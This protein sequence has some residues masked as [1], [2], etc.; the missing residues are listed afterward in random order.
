MSHKTLIKI[1]LLFCYSFVLL[2][3]A[4]SAIALMMARNFFTLYCPCSA[5]SPLHYIISLFTQ[6]H[7]NPKTASSSMIFSLPNFSYSQ[8][9]MIGSS[10]FLLLTIRKLLLEFCFVFPYFSTYCEITES[11]YCQ[12]LDL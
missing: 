6:I 12:I 10:I 1:N 11:L 9:L 3:I 7:L 2:T 8:K 4:V 5:S